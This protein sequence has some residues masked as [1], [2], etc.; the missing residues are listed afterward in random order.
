MVTRRVLVRFNNDAIVYFNRIMSHILCL[1]LQ[2][3][4]MPVKF[5][6]L[7][8]DLLGYAKYAIKT[9]NGKSNET[10]SHSKK[11]PVNGPGQGSTLLGSR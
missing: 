10:Y 9:A 6:A 3:Y 5:T 7:L 11:S 1:C 8:G 4:L 2:S